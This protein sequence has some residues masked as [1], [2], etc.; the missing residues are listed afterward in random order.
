MTTF[1]LTNP[2]DGGL[3]SLRQAIAPSSTHL[4]SQ[5]GAGILVVISKVRITRGNL[6]LSLGLDDYPFGTGVDVVVMDNFI[7]GEPVVA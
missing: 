4:K 2:K 1:T 5:I 7:Y 3:G 6:P